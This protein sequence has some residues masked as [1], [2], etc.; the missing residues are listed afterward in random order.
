[1]LFRETGRECRLNVLKPA[2]S[3]S[4]PDIDPIRMERF[5]STLASP[6]CEKPCIVE[7]AQ[8]KVLVVAC[9]GHDGGRPFATCKPFEH[10]LRIR[11]A[12]NV[13]AQ[14]D[15]HGMIE[16]ARFQIDLDAL[17]QLPEQ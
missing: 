1:M 17:G 11:T 16:R 8:Q 6:E 9:Q 12:I 10:A 14:E 5:E 3:H 7:K 13:I 15:R 4:W 2:T